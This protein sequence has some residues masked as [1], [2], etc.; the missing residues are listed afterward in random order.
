[1]NQSNTPKT[2]WGRGMPA[3]LSRHAVWS[4]Y[5]KV[6]ASWIQKDLIHLLTC[7]LVEQRGGKSWHFERRYWTCASR[8]VKKAA[9]QNS[10]LGKWSSSFSFKNVVY[11]QINN[12]SHASTERGLFPVLSLGSSAWEIIRGWGEI[13]SVLLNNSKR[14]SMVDETIHSGLRLGFVI[15]IQTWCLSLELCV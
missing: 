12:V 3:C 8:I 6:Y 10:L 13:L 1:M 15:F 4:I 2:I 14:L 11:S 5:K 9:M 7:L